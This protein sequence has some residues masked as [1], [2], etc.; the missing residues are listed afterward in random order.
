MNP[1]QLEAH[2]KASWRFFKETL[3]SPKY[4]LAPMVDQSELAFRL[5]S[6]RY[7]ADLCYSPML[8]SRVILEN[9]KY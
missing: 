3:K 9:E 5:L 1:D 6:R 2:I 8:H 4:I 7:G